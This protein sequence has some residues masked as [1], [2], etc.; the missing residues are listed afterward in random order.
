MKDLKRLSVASD[1]V[2]LLLLKSLIEDGD[3][4]TSQLKQRLALKTDRKTISFHLKQLENLG[5]VDGRHIIKEKQG[6]TIRSYKI[7]SQG[8]RI[9]DHIISLK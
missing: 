3:S 8:K 5:L 4:Y 2:R 7:T 1:K 9:Y 6:V